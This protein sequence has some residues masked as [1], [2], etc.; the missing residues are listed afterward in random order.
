MMQSVGFILGLNISL[1]NLKGDLREVHRNC[2]VCRVRE[3]RE[4]RLDFQIK[5]EGNSATS[6][7]FDISRT[8]PHM[9][10]IVIDLFGPLDIQTGV[11]VNKTFYLI[12]V[13]SFLTEIDIVPMRNYSSAAL[14][15]ALNTL[16]VDT[17]HS[18]S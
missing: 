3:G 18:S 14:M 2:S 16:A 12:A 15:L 1:V 6:K 11:E 5:Q 13:S 10:C 4:G 7:L 17:Q 8:S 9:S